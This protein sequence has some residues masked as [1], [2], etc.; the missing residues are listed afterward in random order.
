MVIPLSRRPKI[1][2]EVERGE[3]ELRFEKAERMLALPDC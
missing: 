1:L 3:E 2:G